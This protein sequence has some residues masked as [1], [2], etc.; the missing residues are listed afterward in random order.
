[1]NAYL[2]SPVVTVSMAT[3]NSES[4]VARAVTSVLNQDFRNLELLVFDSQSSDRTRE[5][6][7]DFARGD[8]R[9]RLYLHSERIPWVANAHLGLRRASGKYFMFLDADDYI[10]SNYF[11]QLMKKQQVEHS[12]GAFGKLFHCDNVGSLVTDHP[13]FG[14]AFVFAEDMSRHERISQMILT[15][16]MYGAVNL[17]Y[18]LWLTS[19]L[20]EIGLW[21]EANERRDSDYLFCLR[22]LARGRIAIE[23][24]TWICRSVNQVMVSCQDTRN[25]YPPIDCR[26]VS[27]YKAFVSDWTF[28]YL[29]QIA[30]F[31]RS[32]LRNLIVLLPTLM[33]ICIAIV[34]LPKRYLQRVGSSR[35]LRTTEGKPMRG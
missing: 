25:T 8:K 4:T 18:S 6:L 21:S 10:A 22:A 28:P 14:R 30:R 19:E 2:P 32:D 1:V 27:S 13:A 3:C 15:P 33:R 11:S 31:I 16:D 24:G 26:S 9:I 23:P 35:V 12:I 20:R 17:L 5:I 29:V 34:A 7:C